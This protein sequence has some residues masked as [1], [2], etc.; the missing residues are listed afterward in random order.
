MRANP[1]SGAEEGE[2]EREAVVAACIDVEEGNAACVLGERD[3]VVIRVV[4]AGRV[5][6]GIASGTCQRTVILNPSRAVRA[7]FCRACTTKRG[8]DA[9][10]P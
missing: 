7:A 8:T 10:E 1:E 2:F 5:V 9:A 3:Q 6:L 4:A